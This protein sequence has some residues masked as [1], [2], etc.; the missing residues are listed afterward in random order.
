VYSNLPHGYYYARAF[1][2]GAT[3]TAFGKSINIELIP[4]PTNT[5]TTGIQSAQARLNWTTVSCANYYSVQYRKVSDTAW[6]TKNTVGNVA[7]LVI[8][9]LTPSTAYVWHVA[10]ADTANGV[11]GISA[12]TDSLTFTTA[13]AFAGAQSADESISKNTAAGNNG[14]TTYPN[15]AASSF[16]LQFSASKQD[17]KVSAMLKDMNG[18]IVWSK[19]NTNASSLSS[20]KVDV[21]KLP[22]GI[23]ILQVADLNSN[24]IITK[25][26][27]VS[28]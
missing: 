24:T 6:T 21:S 5:T 1:G 16:T 14:L 22:N 13:A 20:T 28:R 27:V 15:P 18:N 12:Y 8:K 7:F 25:K 3:G 10:S 2:D 17:A 4:K 23:Y 9:N 11:G 26:V 19:T